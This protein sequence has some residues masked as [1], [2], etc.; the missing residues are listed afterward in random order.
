M[1]L[2]ERDTGIVKRRRIVVLDEVGRVVRSEDG[3]AKC[4]VTHDA[5]AMCTTTPLLQVLAS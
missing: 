4:T 3:C 1:R 5:F 2:M